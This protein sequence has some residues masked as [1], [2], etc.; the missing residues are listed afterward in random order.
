HCVEAEPHEVHFVGDLVDTDNDSCPSDSVNHCSVSRHLNPLSED[1]R[2]MVVTARTYN[3][4]TSKVEVLALLLDSG[5]Q[6]SFIKEDIARKLGLAFKDPQPVTTKSFG[7]HT[8][9]ETSYTVSLTLRDQADAE[10]RLILT[11]RKVITSVR[12]NA[13]V[14]RRNIKLL[15]HSNKSM[16]TGDIEIDVLIGIDHYWKIV[17]LS[18]TQRLSSGLTLVHTRFGP[19]TSG[20]EEPRNKRTYSKSLSVCGLESRSEQDGPDPDVRQL[21]EL[22]FIG[23]TDS[24]SPRQDEQVNAEVVQR[25]TILFRL[26]TALFTSVSMEERIIRAFRISIRDA[27]ATNQKLWKQYCVTFQ[28]QERSGIIEEVAE[29]DFD[30]PQVYY[31]PHQAVLKADSTTTAVRIVFDA[32]SHC[33]NS[34]SL[35]DCLHQGPTLLPDLA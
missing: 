22:E 11:T 29:F 24:M 23:I 18:K 26:L 1:P 4:N 30:G 17:D 35:N 25:Y 10:M 8:T 2:L 27:S 28:N 12:A 19:V 7:G 34:P 14:S 5:A 32:S 16:A 21:W 20:L 9:T 31:M 6:H 33:K 13:H 15:R 3:R